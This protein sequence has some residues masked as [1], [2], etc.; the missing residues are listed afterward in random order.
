MYSAVCDILPLS[1]FYISKL[2]SWMA[3]EFGIKCNCAQ[4]VN[5]LYLKIK[6]KD[7][8]SL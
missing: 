4:L 7:L 5:I 6:H 3:R 8:F 1:V 2:F